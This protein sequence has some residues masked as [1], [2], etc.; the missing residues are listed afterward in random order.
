MSDNQKSVLIAATI[1]YL[2]NKI[3]LRQT[4]N[5][6][7]SYRFS[8]GSFRFFTY[9]L[10]K[11]QLWHTVSFGAPARWRR[12][13]F[14]SINEVNIGLEWFSYSPTASPQLLLPDFFS[15]I[16]ILDSYSL[17]PTP[18]FLLDSNSPT[19]TPT[20]TLGPTIC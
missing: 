17:T 20:P 9:L 11:H 10:C 19:P 7:S 3:S 8:A 15:P 2:H 1:S 12:V 4:F 18:R 16:Q 13:N 5:Q 14:Y 6:L